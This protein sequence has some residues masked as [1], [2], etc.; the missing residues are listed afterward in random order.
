M[1]G[2]D[3]GVDAIDH[4]ASGGRLAH[5]LVQV[6]KTGRFSAEFVV[7]PCPGTYPIEF[8][9]GSAEFFG[10]ARALT[11]MGN[12]VVEPRSN[13][14]KTIEYTPVGRESPRQRVPAESVQGP[15][16][17]GRAQQAMLI[18][19]PVNRDEIRPDVDQQRRRNRATP[20]VGPRST[21]GGQGPGQ[22]Q[23]AV[24]V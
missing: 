12:D 17:L 18:V 20:Q 5:D 9:D 6:R 22:E 16:L 7:L 13:I 8:G 15:P 10:L 2:Y 21:A 19:L 24:L 4:L 1:G 3:G 23:G 11:L 14:E